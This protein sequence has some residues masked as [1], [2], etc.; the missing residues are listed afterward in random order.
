MCNFGRLSNYSLPKRLFFKYKDCKSTSFIF[1]LFFPSSFSLSSLL[2]LSLSLSPVHKPA[3]SQ[4]LQLLFCFLPTLILFSFS[5]YHSSFLFF[6]VLSSFFPPL[7]Y[8]FLVLRLSFSFSH[9]FIC[10]TLLKE[11]QT[12]LDIL[13]AVNKAYTA[14]QSKQ[15]TLLV[16]DRLVDLL[17][18]VLHE[19]TYQV[20]FLFLFRSP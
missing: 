1:P 4:V 5:F 18:P 6:H 17:A 20:C 3:L 11:V 14:S 15:T 7:L 12:Q 8:F 13:S 19:F 2:S 9:I 16:V 10:L